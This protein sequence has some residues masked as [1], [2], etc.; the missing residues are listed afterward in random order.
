MKSFVITAAAMALAAPAAFG[1][2]DPH[3]VGNTEFYV[4]GGYSAFD[5]DGATLNAF[6][7]RAGVF[8]THYIGVEGEYSIGIGE[9]E[10]SSETSGVINV[11]SD[12]ELGGQYGGYL[13]GR[14]PVGAKWDLFGRLGY[15]STDLDAT[16]TATDI[17]TGDSASASDTAS[18]DGALIGLGAQ[19]FFTD[20]L[21]LRG[22]YTRFEVDDDDLDGG[23]D[24]FSV[25]AVAKF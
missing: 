12:L 7:A 13:I 5:G 2:P 21:G 10:F 9:E 17:V 19:V 14:I 24:V 3:A 18:L 1:E 22:D 15:G 20:H 16:V 23:L 11:S 25:S 8:L 4:N 6:T